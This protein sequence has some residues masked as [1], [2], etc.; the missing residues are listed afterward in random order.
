MGN[1]LQQLLRTGLAWVLGLGHLIQLFQGSA[2]GLNK[3]EVNDAQFEQVPEDE[4][5][6]T[7]QWLE[8]RST[9]SARRIRTHNQYLMFCMATG[10]ANVL[11]KLAHP[12]A[13]WKT[14]MPLALMSSWR[15]QP[16]TPC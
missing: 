4:K 2:F 16:Q 1:P 12:A 10:A 9:Y 14:I 13:I 6:I 3:E 5:H 11:T 8:C 15:Y 7:W